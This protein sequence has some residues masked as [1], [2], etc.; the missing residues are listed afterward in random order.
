MDL[1]S[2]RPRCAT[3]NTDGCV[4]VTHSSAHSTPAGARSVRKLLNVDFKARLAAK[5][6]VEPGAFNWNL[7]S[8][9]YFFMFTQARL[10]CK[11]GPGGMDTYGN[12]KDG[13]DAL[14]EMESIQAWLLDP[15]LCPTTW[16][17]LL[18]SVH[19][20]SL[21]PSLHPLLPSLAS[22]TCLPH[23]LV[24]YTCS[25]LP[26]CLPS[27]LQQFASRTRSSRLASL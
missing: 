1:R 9:S 27:L 3:A 14:M 24:S 23:L 12:L 25:S 26:L 21:G 7:G 2:S 15:V 6:I 13:N 8:L 11:K 20:P 22:L 10:T 18:T 19:P 17:P 4:S 16:A 5:G